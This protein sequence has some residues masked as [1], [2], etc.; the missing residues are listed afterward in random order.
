MVNYA[1]SFSQSE[2]EKYFEWIITVFN[3][4][5][6][7]PLNHES[8][9]V[10]DWFGILR[11]RLR[12]RFARISVHKKKTNNLTV[13]HTIF[14]MCF[15]IF[16]EKNKWINKKMGKPFFWTIHLQANDYYSISLQWVT[17]K[18]FVMNASFILKFF[19]LWRFAGKYASVHG[20]IMSWK[21]YQESKL[22]FGSAAEFLWQ[23]QGRKKTLK[24]NCRRTKKFLLFR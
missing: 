23:F 16:A 7:L 18:A 17:T 10:R 15:F 5:Y 13:F 21:Y 6:F 4:F 24:H 8:W 14:L 20:R 19:L 3:V 9:F 11:S 1:C 2:L 12:P 22:W